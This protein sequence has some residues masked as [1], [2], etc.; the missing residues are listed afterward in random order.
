MDFPIGIQGIMQHQRAAVHSKRG[1]Y[2]MIV[3]R[4]NEIDLFRDV[5]HESHCISPEQHFIDRISTRRSSTAISRLR[6]K[7]IVLC[8][9]Q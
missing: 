3:W 9:E 2:R 7:K 8:L 5:V 4:M 1:R 6:Y